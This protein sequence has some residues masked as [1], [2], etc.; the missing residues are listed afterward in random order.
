MKGVSFM[1]VIN[2][3][4]LTRQERKIVRKI[5]YL[6]NK[7]NIDNISRTVSYL[8]YYNVNL[9]IKWAF[10]ASQVS[11][12]AGWN[13]CDLEGIW[14]RKI[15][16]PETRSELFRLYEKANWMIF[17]DAY[18]QLLLY[19]YS[20]QKNTPMFHLLRYFSVSSFMEKEWNYYWKKKNQKRL[21]YSLIINEQ[22]LIEKP[23]I[24]NREK[25]SIFYSPA[26]LLQSFGHYSSVLFPT[27]D[28]ELFGMSVSKFTSLDKRIE[29]GKMLASILFH[30]NL[31]QRFYQFAIKTIHTGSRMDYERFVFPAHSNSTPILRLTFPIVQQKKIKCSDWS[32]RKS[33]KRSWRK[34]P[35]TFQPVP[36][37]KW[38]KHKQEQM[39]SFIYLEN[40]LSKPFLSVLLRKRN[41]E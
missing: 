21:L 29:L 2:K 17:Q 38:Y 28:G 22:N 25:R 8:Q 15:L 39:H 13:M 11:R 36:L 26:Y 19:E 33:I 1:V 27:L 34:A 24:K 31:Y 5:K 12:N 30:R 37:T 18:P 9:D 32:E 41:V 3:Y 16:K 23:I 6:T 4:F 14:Y 40:M 20:T 7:N 35:V 10:L